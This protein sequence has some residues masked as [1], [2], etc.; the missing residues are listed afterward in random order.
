M[1]SH[2][3]AIHVVNS[4]HLSGVLRIGAFMLL[5]NALNG[6]QNGALVGFEA[7]EAISLV[8]LAVGLASFP[9]LVGGAYFG[10]LEGIGLGP[11]HRSGFELAA[12][13]HCL[14]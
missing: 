3:L 7:F 13:P 1:S 12:Q 14:G 10:G 11:R 2:W 4:P 5:I 9:L 6:A 8:N